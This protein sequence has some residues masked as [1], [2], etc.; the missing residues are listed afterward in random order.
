VQATVTTGLPA[1]KES[2]IVKLNA[3]IKALQMN[4]TMSMMYLEEMSEKYRTAVEEVDKRHT[5]KAFALNVSL[6]AQQDIINRQSELIMNLTRT[7][8]ELSTK[9]D[10]I[11]RTINQHHD[12][13]TENH[14]FWIFVEI[15]IIILFILFCRTPSHKVTTQPVAAQKEANRRKSEPA[16]SHNKNSGPTTQKFK[17]SHSAVEN[18]TKYKTTP[19]FSAEESDMCKRKKRKK[20]AF[21]KSADG[22]KETRLSNTAGLLF[23]AGRGLISGLTGAFYGNRSVK[24]SRQADALIDQPIVRRSKKES[25]KM[26]KRARSIDMPTVVEEVNSIEHDYGAQTSKGHNENRPKSADSVLG[27]AKKHRNKMHPKSVGR[28]S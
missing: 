8:V 2:I 23:Y 21:V 3:K 1:S 14:V 18:V 16:I 11:T 19:K 13:I 20:L 25:E 24:P 17:R 10:N 7:I 9:L 6:K 26:M 28:F 22:I 12:V 5:N 4:L 15:L 27:P